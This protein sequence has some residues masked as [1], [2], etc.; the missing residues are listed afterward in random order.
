MLGVRFY[1]WRCREISWRL[2]AHQEKG[3]AC[4]LFLRVPF[5]FIP[6]KIPLSSGRGSRTGHSSTVSLLSRAVAPA[7]DNGRHVLRSGRGSGGGGGGG[8]GSKTLLRDRRAAHRLGLRHPEAR[9]TDVTRMA[10]GFRG[11]TDRRVARRAGAAASRI[12][13]AV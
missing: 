3:A 9:L 2:V 6:Q 7:S 4:I 8:S 1:G 10:H 12:K 13:L 11:T 5:C